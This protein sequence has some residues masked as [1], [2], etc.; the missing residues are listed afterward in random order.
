MAYREVKI[1]V[2]GSDGAGKT[3]AIK[4]VNQ[5]QAMAASSEQ[6]VSTVVGMDY[7]EL[8]LDVDLMLRLYGTDDGDCSYLWQRL[9]RGASGH[10]ILSDNRQTAPF[11]TLSKHLDLIQGKGKRFPVAIGVTHYD[12][13]GS[14]NIEEYKTYLESR[15]LQIPVEIVDARSRE[16]VLRFLNTLFSQFA[17]LQ[18]ND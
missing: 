8:S 5:L 6:G 1:I 7:G 18:G 14:P 2:A 3:T 4:T 15:G 16:D 9:V 11:S 10:V 17:Q 12:E 13:S